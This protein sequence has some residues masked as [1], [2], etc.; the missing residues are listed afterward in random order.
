MQETLQQTIP[1]P[2]NKRH[3]PTIVCIDDDPD[4]SRA[5]RLLLSKYDVDVIPAF[6][7]EQGIWQALCKNPDLVITDMRMPQGAGDMVLECL[8]SVP[9]TWAVPVIVLTGVR[10]PHLRGRM[11]RLG[12]VGYLLK[13]ASTAQLLEEI[14]K[15]IELVERDG[16][17]GGGPSEA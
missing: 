10:E 9:K 13:P 11:K 12:A 8:K 6:T 2:R 3:T 17:F 1:A 14:G 7:G 5:V 15:Y 16:N 4:V